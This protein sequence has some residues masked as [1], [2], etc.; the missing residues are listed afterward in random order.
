MLTY[1]TA[2]SYIFGKSSPHMASIRRL[3]ARVLLE[4]GLYEEAATVVRYA[5]VC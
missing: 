3:E 1:A 2:V 4:R 5:Y